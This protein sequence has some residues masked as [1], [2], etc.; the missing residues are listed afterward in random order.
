MRLALKPMPT[1]KKAPA[2]KAPMS[3]SDR[4]KAMQA[5]RAAAKANG[6]AKKPAAKKAKATP[7]TP[8]QKKAL[9][10]HAAPEDMKPCFIEV[11]F[12]TAKDGL[13]S[14]KFSVNRVRG[15]WDNPDAKRFDM[16][17]YD[18]KTVVAIMQRLMAATWAANPQSRLPGNATFQVILRAGVKKADGSVLSRVTNAARLVKR[19]GAAK[20]S[21]KWYEDKADPV[22]RKLRRASNNLRG[23]FTELQLPPSG[24]QPKAD[25]EE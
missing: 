23:A 19:P 10:V 7:L 1:S 9:L 14:P 21:W 6:T 12:K 22:Y 4:M 2:K 13:L 5:A 15:R 3:Q 24:R 16:L 20:A 18:A 25:S 11:K 8:E 17:T